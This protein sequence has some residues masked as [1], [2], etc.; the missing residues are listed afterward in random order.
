MGKQP[1]GA[2]SKILLMPADNLEFI[3]DLPDVLTPANK[4]T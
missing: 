4:K 1:L 3:E 2:P